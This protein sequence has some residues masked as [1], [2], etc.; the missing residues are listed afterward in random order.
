MGRLSTTHVR[1]ESAVSA[2]SE[3][4]LPTSKKRFSVVVEK[5]STG[6]FFL[7]SWQGWRCSGWMGIS[8]LVSPNHF[9]PD[10]HLLSPLS[11]AGCSP[12]V[13]MSA[14]LSK[15]PT[16]RHSA[17]GTN[18][19]ISDTRFCTKVFHCLGTSFSHERTIVESLSLIL[20]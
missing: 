10:H 3:L 2:Y 6:T 5:A 1:L 17:R 16:C 14:G 13:P 8:K 15:V 7:S 19:W 18:C 12:R 20:I 11:S 4:C 9:G